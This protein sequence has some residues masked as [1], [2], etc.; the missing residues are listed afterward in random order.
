MLTKENVL[1]LLNNLTCG[2]LLDREDKEVGRY[3]KVEENFYVWEWTKHD[4]MG[5]GGYYN[6]GKFQDR[7]GIEAA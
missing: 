2:K 5:L 6:F 1:D 7:Y 3:V 4:V